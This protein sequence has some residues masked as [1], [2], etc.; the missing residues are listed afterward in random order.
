MIAFG[1]AVTEPTIYD[2][3][4]GPGI[5]RAA[6]PD[7]L[8]FADQAT[9]SLFRNYNRVLEQA[10]VHDGL[11]ALVLVHQDVEIVESDFCARVRASLSDPDVAIVG[12]VGAV[13]VRQPAWWKGTVAWAAFSHHYEEFGGGEFDSLSW[14]PEAGPSHLAPGE[15]D[16]IDGLAMVL[17]PWAVR[18][19]CFDESLGQFHGYD[20]DIC[21]QAR[22]AGKK[23]VTADFRVIH[24]HSLEQIS[25]PEEWIA[26]YIRLGEKWADHLPEPSG[27]PNQ[28]ALR[29]EA[30]AACAEARGITQ[31]LR[32]RAMRAQLARTRQE[33]NGS[34]DQ[35][36][37][38]RQAL[39]LARQQ[40]EGVRSR[41]NSQVRGAY[42]TEAA[43][44]AGRTSRR[45]A[46]VPRVR[47][48]GAGA[49]LA[50][51]RPASRS[52]ATRGR[53]QARS[54]AARRAGG[55]PHQAPGWVAPM[56][57]SA[58]AQPK[59]PHPGK[60]P[61][62]DYAVEELG[63]ESF[64]SLEFDGIFGEWA[65]Y[66][67]DKPTIQHGA[68]VD[69]RA[70]RA[71]AHLLSAIELAAERPGM[72]VLDRA[73]SDPR[74]VSEIGEVDAILLFDVLHHMVDPAWDQVLDLYA[75]VTS[76]F[77]IANPQWERGETTVRLV[78]LGREQ[79]LE[80]VPP[81]DTHAELFDRLDD[82]H[83]GQQRLY[84]DATHVWQRGITDADL[85]A[86]L[87]E[88]GFSVKHEREVGRPSQAKGFVNKAFVFSRS[89]RPAAG[90]GTQS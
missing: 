66:T 54:D 85:K 87:G 45:L 65:F 32:A 57:A 5:R 78:D 71:R 68:L 72:R 14:R 75:P 6:E 56:Q 76:S 86:K 47:L 64:A 50:R 41:Q 13:G 29:A 31:W 2:R 26:A 34:R 18:E 4:A 74:T 25:D 19:L 15:V 61:A 48:A 43:A 80:A 36:K 38:T 46:Q 77:V 3:F 30:E 83:K 28:R 9:G 55:D 67:I 79:F 90:G 53:R 60:A 44:R 58:G 84:R 27:D 40:L 82:W 89:D 17:S 23:V 22:T 35:L 51:M 10:R 81:T 8:V 33:L 62:I 69:A 21:M 88:L 70:R 7:S 59:A 37:A 11:E 12:C 49:W 39:T 63:I 24:H 16:A 52:R 1:V 42:E 73:F 20:F